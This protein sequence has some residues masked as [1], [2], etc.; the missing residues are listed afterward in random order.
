MSRS[1]SAQWTDC[2]SSAARPAIQTLSEPILN[3]ARNYPM[4]AAATA[5]AADVAVPI[6]Q[7]L[8][9]RLLQR[10]ILVQRVIMIW[11]LLRVGSHRGIS[12]RLLLSVTEV[13]A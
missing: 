3:I 5:H 9:A 12:F 11:Y 13:Y 7:T 1:L 10:E 2:N 6:L 4:R 8:V